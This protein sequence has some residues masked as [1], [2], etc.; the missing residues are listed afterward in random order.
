MSPTCSK[1]DLAGSNAL[2]NGAA[3]TIFSSGSKG[4]PRDAPAPPTRVYVMRQRAPL[5][6]C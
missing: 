2:L 1:N 4:P 5:H 6:Q 3:L